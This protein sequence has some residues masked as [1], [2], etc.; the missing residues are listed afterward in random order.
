MIISLKL[1]LHSWRYISKSVFHV[2]V[3]SF[4]FLFLLILIF[5]FPQALNAETLI[6]S[7]FIKDNNQ[8]KWILWNPQSDKSRTYGIYDNI[9]NIIFDNRESRVIYEKADGIY[10]DSWP[11]GVYSGEAYH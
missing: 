4:S 6:L 3:F 2:F 7:Y 5:I 8:T 9:S 11:N 1:L 10:Q